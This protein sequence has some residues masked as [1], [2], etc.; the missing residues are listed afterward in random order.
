MSVQDRR[1]A[2]VNLSSTKIPVYEKRVHSGIH[3]R[4]LTA[5]GE[6]IGRIFPNE[7][8]IVLPNSS[9]M[10]GLTSFQIYFRDA[11]KNCVYGYI[12]TS[13]GLTLPDYAWNAYQYPYQN[14]NSNGSTLTAS[15]KTTLN[16]SEY[17][18][19]RSN[20]SCIHTVGFSFSKTLAFTVKVGMQ[21][22]NDIG[23]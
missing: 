16:G 14:Y 5:G 18:I 11:N 4:G 22:V 10:Y 17:R 1:Y 9:D 15:K 3:N 21:R 8:Y 13:T 7:F 2:S 20:Y 23:W 19:F 6:I 12:E